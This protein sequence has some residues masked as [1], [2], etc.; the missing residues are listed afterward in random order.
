MSLTV[1]DLWDRSFNWWR[2]EWLGE[3]FDDD[4]ILKV[5]SVY[6]V[7]RTN[8]DIAVWTGAKNGQFSVKTAYLL[9]QQARFD[10]F[11]SQVWKNLWAEKNS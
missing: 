9:D 4:T 6:W 11:H 7:G 2:E 8:M 5:L 3:L 10:D 1:G